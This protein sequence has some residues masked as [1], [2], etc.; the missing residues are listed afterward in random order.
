MNTRARRATSATAAAVVCSAGVFGLAGPADAATTPPMMHATETITTLPYTAVNALVPD[1]STG[2]VFV[3]GGISGNTVTTS[4]EVL[5]TAGQI[6]G[7]IT[8]QSG[9]STLQLSADGTTLYAADAATR[10]ITAI[11]TSTLS[12]TASYSTGSA[13]AASMAL[14]GG[15]LWFS[16]SSDTYLHELDLSTGTVSTTTVDAMQA[17]SVLAASPAAPNVLA[18][19]SLGADPGSVEVYTVASGAPVGTAGGVVGSCENLMGVTVNPDGTHLDVNCGYPYEGLEVA[20]DAPT[21]VLQTYPTGAY[22]DSLAVAADGEVL[23]GTSFEPNSVYEFNPASTTPVGDFGTPTWGDTADR[24][25]WG[26]DDSVFYAAISSASATYATLHTYKQVGGFTFTTPAVVH[27]SDTYSVSGQLA[28]V[29]SPL[30]NTQVKVTRTVNGGQPTTVGTFVTNSSG[31]FS[32]SDECSRASTV[33]YTA[34]DVSA[35]TATNSVTMNCIPVVY[36]ITG[37]P[38]P[39]TPVK[40]T[41]VLKAVRAAR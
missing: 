27:P 32:F 40:S 22:T 29:S 41:T 2:R 3:S 28:L 21:T 34:V 35:P 19:G 30:A 1:P 13:A 17:N 14:S 7:S 4:I 6:V 12:Q 37:A 10:T 38:K 16:S 9:V 25:A 39:G 26:A 8:G 15:N 11:N 18:V 20:L 31:G 33:I 36:P 23:I 5:N 24:V